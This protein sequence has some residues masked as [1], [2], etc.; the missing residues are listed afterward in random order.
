MA[1]KDFIYDDSEPVFTVLTPHY[2]WEWALNPD[3]RDFVVRGVCKPPN[4]FH[5]FMMRWC[6]G[7]HSRLIEQGK[8]NG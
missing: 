5:R 1:Y 4:R 3:Y 6:L 2:T 8:G 7:I